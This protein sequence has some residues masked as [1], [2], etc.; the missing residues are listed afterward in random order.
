[1]MSLMVEVWVSCRRINEEGEVRMVLEFVLVCW[2][3]EDLGGSSRLCILRDDPKVKA[4][5]T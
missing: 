5:T 3:Q 2:K 4:V 1:M